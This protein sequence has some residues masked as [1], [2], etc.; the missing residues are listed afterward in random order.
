MT[1]SILDIK[2]NEFNFHKTGY[3]MLQ[4]V[5][6]NSNTIKLF[7]NTTDGEVEFTNF[8]SYKMNDGNILLAIE[9]ID[10][11]FADYNMV[12]KDGDF[13]EIVNTQLFERLYSYYNISEEN[14][15]GF[16]IFE[17]SVPVP[18]DGYGWRCDKNRFGPQFFMKNDIDY[19]PL[20]A[21]LSEIIVYEPVFSI[22]NTAHIISV[23]GTRDSEVELFHLEEYELP[24]AAKTLPEL[25]KLITEWA[26]VSEEPWNNTERISLKAKA[27][28][29]GMN[30]DEKFINDINSSQQDMQIVKFLKND[31]D[32]KKQNPT[33]GVM[34][35]AIDKEI[36][37]K[38]SHYS[39]SH[40]LSLFPG[41]VDDVFYFYEEEMYAVKKRQDS[42]IE[43]LGLNFP[44]FNSAQSS[45]ITDAL[46][47][48]NGKINAFRSIYI[49]CLGSHLEILESLNDQRTE[50]I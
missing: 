17:N 32:A 34:T 21:D 1:N 37:K 18:E 11:L 41:C 39:L 45:L 47:E 22:S 31:A 27:F 9:R 24:R 26:E 3:Y 19:D 12:A 8:K 40:I 38:T 16:F 13:L 6:K 42:L 23:H 30:F 48:K 43:E 4:K 14:K 2:Q 25:L 35:E 28:L 5:G 7:I 44:K 15:K 20:F 33:L 50:T 46:K 29:D 10:G 36:K 49:N